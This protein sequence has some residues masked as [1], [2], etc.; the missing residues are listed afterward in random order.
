MPAPIG[1]RRR[2]LFVG[3]AIILTCLACFVAAEVTVRLLLRY[4][5]PDTV[6]QNSLGYL[7]AVYARHTLAPDQ[8]L[9][10]DQA[11]GL[12]SEADRSYHTYRV[13][14]HGFRGESFSL[15]KPAGVCRLVVLG[16]SAVFDLNASQGQDWPRLLE[17]DLR[18]R[19]LVDVEVINAGIPGH[20]STDALG[21]LITRIWSLEPDVVLLYNAW[22]DI[23]YFRDL[24]PESPL[25]SLVEP[26]DPDANPFH[27]Y[28][29]SLDW[30]LS[31]SQLYVK[32]RNVY[33]LRKHRPGLEGGQTARE[34][35]TSYDDLGVR[36]YRLNVELF[37]AASRKIGALPVL[38]TQASLVSPSTPEEAR[39]EIAYDYPGLHHE[40]LARAF[41]E[42][43]DV[44]RDVARETGAALIDPAGSLSGRPELFAD[45]VHTTGEGSAAL[46]E[47]A[48]GPLATLLADCGNGG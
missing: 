46:A 16:G 31:R 18:D 24:S 9:D 43:N 23:K 19:G 42:C 11:W 38:M 37:V 1:P 7:P 47:A 4:N 10:L 32:L 25:I 34:L 21:R 5:T 22:N 8:H 14:E 48:A 44:V 20:A 2:R 33:Y 13:N 39:E 41:G 36:Q 30:L 12:R 45:H 35:A 15:D 40:A 26:H 28:R 3:L 27:S 17:A 6:R 29:G